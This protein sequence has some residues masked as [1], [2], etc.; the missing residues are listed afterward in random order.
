VK[1]PGRLF[2]LLAL[3][4]LTL[5]TVG[6][7]VLSLAI[8][9]PNARQ[10]LQIAS[11]NTAAASS[12][13]VRLRIDQAVP[14]ATTSTRATSRA[15]VRYHA[16]DQL[17]L[18]EVSSGRVVRERVLGRTVYLSYDGGHSWQRLQGQAVT[19]AFLAPLHAL[20]K[21]NDVE[22]HGD[23]YVVTNATSLARAF[24]IN[25]GG[26]GQ[27]HA[28][29]RATI[30]GE[31]LRVLQVNFRSS[32]AGAARYTQGFALVDQVPTIKAPPAGS[33]STT[34]SLIPGG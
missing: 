7:I 21:L 1:P 12:F 20:S 22:Q 27:V 32:R 17:S 23:V 4:I 30:Q 24:G 9:P 29:V 5:L 10:H 28:T 11:R 3:G 31:F 19:N 2:A 33:T 13:L 26:V 25:V 14:G 34:P 8:A 18:S 16:P 15:T 6:A